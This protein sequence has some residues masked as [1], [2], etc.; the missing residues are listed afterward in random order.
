MVRTASGTT[1]EITINDALAQIIAHAP[2]SDPKHETTA[3]ATITA[4]FLMFHCLRRS[5]AI[6]AKCQRLRVLAVLAF[7]V[8]MLMPVTGAAAEPTAGARPRIGL[9]LGGGGARGAAHVGVLKVLEEMR[10]PVDYV[11]GTSMGSIVGGL[12][13]SGMTPDEIDREM[14]KMDWADLFQ[15]SPKRAD[16]S[17]R[18]KEDDFN[19][20]FKA[21][22]GVRDGAIKFPLAYIRGQ[23]F[24]LELKRLTLPV[25]NVTDFDRLPIPYRAVAT[26]LETG[27]E[28]VLGK[29]ILAESIRASM[30]V[31]GAFDPVEINGQLL[32]DGGLANNVP[33]SVARSMG[34]D[35]FI[36]VDVGEGLSK[37]DEIKSAL[38]VSGQL[39]GF[40]FTLN[41]EAQL[42]SLG[43]RD[44]LIRPKLGDIGGGSFERVGEAIPIGEQA[45]RAAADSLKR[46]SIS[47]E[48]YARHLAK[49]RLRHTVDPVVHFVR[50]N[51]QSHV[52]DDVIAERISAEP[53]KPL[54]VK[55]LDAD[56]AQIYGLEI[57]ESVRYE[58]VDENGV[59]GLV[60]TAKEKGWGPGYLQFGMATSNDFKG[61]ATMRV[62]VL[63]TLTEIN[64]L[65]GEWRIGGQVGD[66]PGIFTE[67]YQPLDALSR[68][69]VSGRIG[70]GQQNINQFDA[71]GNRI[72]R[73]TLT[74]G[75]VQ[76]AFGRE[77]GT[78]GEARVG[79]RRINGSA[80]V[81]TGTPAPDI[82]LDSDEVFVRL[83]D[84]KMDNIY[85]PRDGH[86]GRIEYLTGK[87]RYGSEVEYDQWLFTYSHAHSWG[88]NTLIGSLFGGTTVDD[89]A[90]LNRLF[91]LGGFLRLSGYQIDELTGQSAGLVQ[92]IYMRRLLRVPFFNAYA[93][94]SVEVGNVW[95]ASEDISWRSSVTTGSVFV[96]FDTPIGPLYI[97]YGQAPDDNQSLY[98]YLGPRFTY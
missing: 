69:F 60:V 10:I 13:A 87:E 70:Y 20:A 32:I 79:I 7:T 66:E 89:N 15:D 29:G 64:K 40:L 22:L 49:R 52:G 8:A 48:Q 81:T 86:I 1:R 42:K 6:R 11:A 9:V 67:I 2:R 46:Y 45:A 88:A 12:Y 24:D 56:I 47:P 27:K 17:F 34:A 50:I 44:V 35:V 39:A 80:E 4:D 23:K 5:C 98:V 71:T 33:V 65:N 38:D 75:E 59:T 85:F 3:A 83:S 54:D 82:D 68:F 93:G 16:R 53:G 95:Q 25:Y 74:G 62:G 61:D 94:G 72:A 77:F 76:F 43:P 90:P 21:K 91:R 26:D 31:P 92:L 28:V 84:D 30:A 96:G 78:W 55:Q 41:T 58:L 18:R 73:Y 14:Q 97:A 51:N 63:Y 57:F 19:Y 37:R 36:V